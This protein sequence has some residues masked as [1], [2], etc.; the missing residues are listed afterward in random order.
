MTRLTESCGT[1]RRRGE[2]IRCV[3]ATWHEMLWHGIGALRDE[4][5]CV[6]VSTHRDGELI[7]RVI[8]RQG[9][10][11]ARGSSTRG[12]AQGLRDLL[13]AARSGAGDL[14]ITVDGPRGPR[15]E[16]KDGVLFAAAAAGLP[17]VPLAIA[18]DRAWTLGTWDRL[19]VGQP[20]ARVAVCFG[21]EVWLPPGCEREELV[22][23]HR[24]RVL[25]AMDAAEQSC[26]RAI[27]RHGGR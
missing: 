6:L 20:L 2:S 25:A 13:R 27:S 16:L 21:D 26:L 22:Q 23:V 9:F 4:G 5:V 15:R 19:I 3:Y 10:R 17:I 12:G 7:A 24:G 18:V 8:E 11:L 1:R 14:C